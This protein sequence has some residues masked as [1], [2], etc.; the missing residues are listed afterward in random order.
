M[1]LAAVL[2]VSGFVLLRTSPGAREERAAAERRASGAEAGEAPDQVPTRGVDAELV[3]R[4]EA[5][6]KIDVTG[7]LAPVR[8]VVI[9][10]E[11]A[12]RVVALEVEE[13]TQVAADD[14]L[15]RLDAALLDAAV[16]RSRA[17]LLRA[18]AAEKLAAAEFARQTELREQGVASTA[19]LDRAVSEE[20]STAAQV[21]E[22][23]ASL[24]D[25]ETRLEK[26]RIRAPFAGIVSGLDLEPGVYLTPG[27]DVA[28]L[29]DLS[30]V[31]IEVGLSDQEI[32]AVAHDQAVR[33]TVEAWPGRFF[34]GRVV[35]PGR[36]A[37]AQTRK[38][39]VAVRVPNAD[40][41]LLPGMLGTVRFELGD[42]RPV[43][44]V[45]RS[46]VFREFD[47]EYVYALDEPNADGSHAT[48]RRRRVTTR[49]VAFHPELVDLL[50]GVEAGERIATSGVS[51]LQEGLR[52][53]VRRTRGEDAAVAEVAPLPALPERP[54]TSS[55]GTAA[56]EPAS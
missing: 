32:L 12:G 23:Q 55:E 27:T 50:S 51:D 2:V 1:A 3:R 35:R 16:A 22:A 17:A 26:T 28:E 21:A 11:V 34:E 43:L 37:D 49:P 7:V 53:R 42:A 10:A 31:E 19:V 5:R 44:R 56:G 41:E 13:H 52:V 54:E 14:V 46:A 47:L 29:A 25:A 39:P 40:G 18:R 33:V 9:G 30:E 15:V 24:L 38:Y 45:A 36:T 48:A 20:R 6:T 4:V 8:H